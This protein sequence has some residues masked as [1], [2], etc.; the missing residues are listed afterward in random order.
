MALVLQYWVD[1]DTVNPGVF[2]AI[3]WV[4][5]ILI[6]YFGVRV[7]GDAEFWLSS[8]K[9]TVLL[10]II[11]LSIILAAG[12][13]PNHTASGFKYVLINARLNEWFQFNIDHCLGYG[14]TQELSNRT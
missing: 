14:F 2:I 3:F 9:L 8:V 6:N 1:R 13:R 4:V 12:G 11:L 5:I 7:F 10:G